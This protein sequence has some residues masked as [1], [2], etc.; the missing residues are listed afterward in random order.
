MTGALRLSVAGVRRQ[1][2][3]RQISRWSLVCL[4]GQEQ[5]RPGMAVELSSYVYRQSRAR[6]GLWIS[7]GRPH[8]TVFAFCGGFLHAL[9]TLMGAWFKTRNG[10]TERAETILFEL[11]CY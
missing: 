7:R 3:C 11:Q 10:L 5:K 2:G 9:R 6:Q 1:K 8:Q 4:R